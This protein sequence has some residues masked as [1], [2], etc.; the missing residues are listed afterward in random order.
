MGLVIGCIP[1]GRAPL[2]QFCLGRAAPTDTHGLGSGWVVLVLGV[3]VSLSCVIRWYE[4]CRGCLC[5]TD[6][7]GCW[8]VLKH[9][10]R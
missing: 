4:G 8:D 10:M 6:G 3:R 9:S 7:V 1:S 5:C 2:L